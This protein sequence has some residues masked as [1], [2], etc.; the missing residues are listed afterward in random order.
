MVMV[1]IAVK[2]HH[3][4]DNSYK[5]KHLTRVAYSL[6]VQSTIIIMVGHGSRQADIVL[7]RQL[8][9]LH[10]AGKQEVV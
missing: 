1:P 9:V 3:V 5:E 6:E 7:E 2:R 8:R 4:H 10:L